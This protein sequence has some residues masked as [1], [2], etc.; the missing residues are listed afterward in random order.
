MSKFKRK[1]KEGPNR[2]QEARMARGLIFR[3]EFL[4]GV[5][6]EYDATD[7][8]TGGIISSAGRTGCMVALVFAA[9]AML[10]EVGR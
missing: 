3:R 6:S 8:G 7:P 9:M 1:G 2:G 10:K 5:Q 4:V